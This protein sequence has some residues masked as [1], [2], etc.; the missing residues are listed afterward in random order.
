MKVFLVTE[1][2]GEARHQ[3]RI[4]MLEAYEVTGLSPAALPPLGEK[5]RS[6]ETASDL[7]LYGG[8]TADA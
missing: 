2:T 6:V 1:F 4:D 7:R 5:P 8:T 3:R